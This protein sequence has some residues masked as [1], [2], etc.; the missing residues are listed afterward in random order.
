MPSFT[1]LL[2]PARRSL[3]R[4][5]GRL[6][7]HLTRLASQV[8]E[9]VAEAIGQ[10]V[11]GVV[12][13]AVHAALDTGPAHPTLGPGPT[14]PLSRSPSLWH[15][16]G[17]RSWSGYTNDLDDPDRLPDRC[18]DEVQDEDNLDDPGSGDSERSATSRWPRALAAGCQAVAWWLGRR[19]GRLSLP[20]ALAVGVAA[21]AVALLS[22]SVAV[23]GACLAGV[24]VALLAL[25]DASRS[26][27]A[28]LAA[29]SP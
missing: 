10:A 5:L 12:G 29:G 14:Q 24:A 4:H 16:P 20:S 17:N 23:A 22:E 2:R 3:G 18:G 25:V 9:A 8:R 11:A 28:A 13:E 19:P 6:G 21:G 27:A 26:G 15:E 1:A 7:A